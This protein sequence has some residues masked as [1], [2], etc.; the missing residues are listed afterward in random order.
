VYF[1]G[2]YFS[3]LIKK[4][5]LWL[6]MIAKPPQCRFIC[7]LLSGGTGNQFGETRAQI[8]HLKI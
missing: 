5:W 8:Y 6:G 1:F 4:E 7:A 2:V 3:E